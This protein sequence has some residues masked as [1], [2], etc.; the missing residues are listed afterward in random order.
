M[1]FLELQAKT[2]GETGRRNKI[3]GSLILNSGGAEEGRLLALI[4]RP[5]GD[6]FS[7][8]RQAPTEDQ[9]G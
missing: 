3:K 6:S 8:P 1:G 4:P 7:E 5:W 9:V 2:V